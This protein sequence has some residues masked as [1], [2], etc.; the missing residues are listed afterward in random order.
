VHD[1]V[2]AVKDWLRDLPGFAQTR[3]G[4]LDPSA[5]IEYQWPKKYPSSPG[6]RGPRPG[7]ACPVPTP[8]A[9]YPDIASL[10]DPIQPAQPEKIW[11]DSLR[12]DI[13]DLL[14]TL[15]EGL[16]DAEDDLGID[17]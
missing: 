3:P 14:D 10:D 7:K 11:E 17:H 1:Q 16:G 5:P 15:G 12:K 4:A 2:H 8:D 9:P 13:K 6:Q